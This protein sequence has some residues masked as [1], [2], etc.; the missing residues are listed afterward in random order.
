[1][2]R[3]SALVVVFA[4]LCCGVVPTS[5]PV[6]LK[7]IIRVRTS[8]SCQTY[9]EKVLTA[10]AGL[11]VNDAVLATGRSLIARMGSDLAA[12][13]EDAVAIDRYRLGQAVHAAAD[14]L[15]KVQTLLAEAEQLPVDRRDASVQRLLAV[16]TKLDIVAHAQ[17]AALNVLS[18]TYDGSNLDDLYGRGDQMRGA[19]GEATVADK[20]IG[21][22]DPLLD[23]GGASRGAPSRGP[24]TVEQ[25]LEALGEEPVVA[26]SAIEPASQRSPSHL[27]VLRPR[28]VH[29]AGRGMGSAQQDVAQNERSAS[30]AVTS[31]AKVC[32]QDTV[33]SP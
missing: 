29:M 10:L 20:Q 7:T 32:G 30:P 17:N 27:P 23:A 6:P 24:Q 25:N 15:G 9:R 22:G 18:G 14:N 5:S 11:R 26:Q 4:V 33:T 8:I 2:K 1:M 21:L 19:N 13:A 16:K 28:G 3:Y 31:E 12:G